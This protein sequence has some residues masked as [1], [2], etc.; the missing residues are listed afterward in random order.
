MRPQARLVLVLGLLAVLAQLV[1]PP[2]RIIGH[3]VDE[4]TV[5]AYKRK[6]IWEGVRP[7]EWVQKEDGSGERILFGE[8]AE[9][10][11]SQLVV[12]VGVTL[13]LTALGLLL[14]PRDKTKAL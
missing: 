2:K 11:P 3:T 1:Y 8:S 9:V 14:A 7:I 6:P 12:P 4:S 5:V 10:A 13:V